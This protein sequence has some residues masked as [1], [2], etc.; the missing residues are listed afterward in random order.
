MYQPNNHP[1][2]PPGNYGYPHPTNFPEKP[3][4]PHDPTLAPVNISTQEQYPLRTAPPDK[5]L[6]RSRCGYVTAGVFF[7]ALYSTIMSG[8]W[9]M[10]SILQPRWGDKISSKK[11]YLSP[12]NAALVSSLISKTIEISF[13]AVFVA[14]LGQV[15]TR[16]A[17]SWK[18]KGI[19]LA[20]LTMKNWVIRPGTVFSHP[21]AV[22][23][24]G[25]TFHGLLSFAALIATILYMTASEALVEPKLKYSP[26]K[27][28]DLTATVHTWYGNPVYAARKCQ[29]LLKENP[30]PNSEI[31]NDQ[32]S[33]Y[34]FFNCL[35][36]QF[37][38]QSSHDLYS[39]L[40]AWNNTDTTGLELVQRPA[41][42]TMLE[43]NVTLEASWAEP[44][45]KNVS[46]L[47]TQWGRI[48]DNATISLPHPRVW[49]AFRSPS[50]GILQ[51]EDLGGLGGVNIKA[52]VASPTLNVLCANVDEDELKPIIYEAWPE[53][54][55]KNVSEWFAEG[56][57]WNNK[58]VVDDIFGWG[59][60]EKR[61]RPLFGEYPEDYGF[62]FPEQSGEDETVQYVL[63][64]AP[65]IGNY[66][67]CQLRSWLSADCS[68]RL[69]IGGTPQPALEAHCGDDKDRHSYQQSLGSAEQV[70]GIEE[71][72]GWA[73]T[74]SI[75]A[76]AL[77]LFNVDTLGVS[78]NPSILTRLVLKTPELPTDSPSMAEAFCVFT[79]ASLSS[80]ALGTSFRPT[81]DYGTYDPRA[82]NDTFRDYNK[83]ETFHASVSSQQYTSGHIDDWQKVFYPVLGFVFAA[84]L[85]CLL[86]FVFHLG[87]VEDFTE[88]ENHFA[89][90]INSP[91]TD[92][93]VG[94]A[95]NGPHRS[96]LGVRWRIASVANASGYCFETVPSESDGA[97]Q[98]GPGVYQRVSP[99]E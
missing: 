81:W 24:A 18:T 44:K 36:L 80:S 50:S 61:R 31:W 21:G 16:R 39:Y 92:K 13:A 76:E 19:T 71:T 91:P 23:L 72:V 3:G 54:N 98:T 34:E 22:S 73:I 69:N 68:T 38:S 99:Q 93:M 90:A 82:N 86:Y 40:L 75:L 66:T 53:S 1:V 30:D 45:Y 9:L 32:A 14:Y 27:N 20:D 78:S 79:L 83:V 26:W 74:G 62:F 67:L 12:S 95:V 89:L 29:P 37:S 42:N 17:M 51:P 96:H 77:K 59:D 46:Q 6:S 56:G 11:G 58:T 55:T 4:I 52:S 84:N 48:I 41:G 25:F 94:S 65:N 85:M 43:N 33:Y 64:K 15:F 10:T 7:L 63:T 97:A 88:P 8:L 28:K 35:I 70:A 60:Q 49:E 47:Y 87:L 5:T 57:N 2:A